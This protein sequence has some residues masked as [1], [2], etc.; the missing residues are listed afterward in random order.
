MPKGVAA[1]CRSNVSVHDLA[2][3]AV[4][5]RDRELAFQAVALCPVTS[6]VLSLPKIREMFDEMWEAEKQFLTYFEPG[7]DGDM[8]ETYTE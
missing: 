8:P 6:A 2:V 4:L 3:Q 5:K 1:L 7:Q